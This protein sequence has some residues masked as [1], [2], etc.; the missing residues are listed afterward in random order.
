[1]KIAPA[2]RQPVVHVLDASRAVTVVGQLKSAE[3]REAFAAENRPRPG[4]AAPRARS[5]SGRRSRSCPWR[6][7]GAA[8]RRSTGRP[9][10]SPRPAFTGVRALEVPLGELV[11]FID[12][13]PFFHTWE[14]KGTYPR[15]FENPEWGARARELFDDA[16]ALLRRIVDERRL[17]ARAVYGFF[18]ANA[19]GDDI[20]VY[21]D[22][23][24]HGPRSPRS[25]RCASRWT[26]A[27][28]SRTRPSPTSSSPRET[29]RL[30]YLGRLR[31]HHRDRHR[32]ARRSPSR[33]RTTTTARSWPRPWP[34]AWRRRSRSGSTGGPGADWGYGTRRE[35]SSPEELIRERYR[36]IR[37]APGYPACPDH[38]EKGLLFDLLA[39]ERNAGISPHRDASPCSRPPR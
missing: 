22:E 10:R 30:D 1:M 32:A 16:Q 20:E 9:T 18:P 17:T 12:W 39:A 4:A 6:R 14:L 34:T 15:I 23:A 5:R 3:A 7:R 29:G 33:R 31:G 21:T 28:P 36:G 25:T 13:S 8:G 26:R 24:R 2:Y 38:T 35:R 11:P 19:V 37:P 27:R